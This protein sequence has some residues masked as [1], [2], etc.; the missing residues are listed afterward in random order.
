MKSRKLVLMKLSAGQQWRHRHREQT[1]GHSGG[2]EGGLTPAH[3]HYHLQKTTSEDLLGDEGSSDPGLCDSA[4]KWD[5]R[6]GEREGMC[7]HLWLIHVAVSETN[8]STKQ[9]FSS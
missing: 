1:C 4:E 7:V 8:D 5:G 9:S 6:R 3:T 2:R